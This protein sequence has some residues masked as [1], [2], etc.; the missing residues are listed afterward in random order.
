MN[1]LTK[2]EA[3]IPRFSIGSHR[4]YNHSKYKKYAK[5]IMKIYKKYINYHPNGE[6]V[7]TAIPVNELVPTAMPVNGLVART[8]GRRKKK[9]TSKKKKTL[10]K[11]T[12]KNVPGYGKRLVRSFKNGKKY[13]MAG[14][15]KIKL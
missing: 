5:K 8:G 4:T 7:P 1:E 14:G 11:K 15:R 6:N 3:R 12:Y 2:P 13:V 9:T 10:K